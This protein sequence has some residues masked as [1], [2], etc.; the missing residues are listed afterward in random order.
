MCTGN[1]AVTGISTSVCRN[2][3]LVW[4][5]TTVR[6]PRHMTTV[7]KKITTTNS[8]EGTHTN[9]QQQLNTQHAWV[10]HMQNLLLSPLSSS[11]KDL[12]LICISFLE[13]VMYSPPTA[14][15][16]DQ[17][18][19]FT[20]NWTDHHND[21]HG[22]SQHTRHLCPL[23]KVGFFYP[24]DWVRLHHGG[25]GCKL[26]PRTFLVEHTV[27]KSCHWLTC[28]VFFF[29]G[30]HGQTGCNPRTKQDTDQRDYIY[31]QSKGRIVRPPLR[32][33]PCSPSDEPGWSSFASSIPGSWWPRKTW[34]CWRRPFPGGQI[35]IPTERPTNRVLS[36]SDLNSSCDL[37]WVAQQ[38]SE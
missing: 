29:K 8:W 24:C 13:A 9:E 37:N 35:R 38:G 16:P 20:I 34:K 10:F 31:S 14:H 1:R 15:W 28:A 22:A 12:I 11:Y 23:R 30:L 7:T 6:M 17:K 19:W 21:D 25:H 26:R 4:N 27:M 33:T 3:L 5:I 18:T 2:R 36:E 32:G